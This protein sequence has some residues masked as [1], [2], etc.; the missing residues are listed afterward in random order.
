MKKIPFPLIALVVI[1]AVF[2]FDAEWHTDEKA[3]C[4]SLGGTYNLSGQCYKIVVV[5][6]PL[7]VIPLEKK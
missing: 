4:A 2:L 7:T 5:D 3:K 6:V 1:T